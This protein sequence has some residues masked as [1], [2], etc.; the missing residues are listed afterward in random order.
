VCSFIEQAKHLVS[1]LL[2]LRV[3]VACDVSE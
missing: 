3:R 1:I 2:H